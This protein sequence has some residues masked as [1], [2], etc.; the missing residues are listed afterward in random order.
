M[1]TIDVTA[2]DIFTGT[3]NSTCF[4]PVIRAIKRVLPSAWSIDNNT[5]YPGYCLRLL[6]EDVWE[7]IELP[8]RVQSFIAAFDTHKPVTPFSFELPLNNATR[9]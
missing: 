5:F 6:T 3:P 2:D 1:L 4:C 8:P 9:H 7:F